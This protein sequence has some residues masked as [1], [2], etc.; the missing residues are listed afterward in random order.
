MLA[1]HMA[2]GKGQEN[3]WLV[4]PQNQPS[5][6]VHVLK[7]GRQIRELAAGFEADSSDLVGKNHPPMEPI[8]FVG[9]QESIGNWDVHFTAV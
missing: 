9:Y 4:V 7:D 1:R 3:I 5:G 6:V 2:L 8:I